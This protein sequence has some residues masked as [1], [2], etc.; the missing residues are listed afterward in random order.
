MVSRSWTPSST[1]R[2]A[3]RQLCELDYKNSGSS[4]LLFFHRMFASFRCLHFSFMHVFFSPTPDDGATLVRLDGGAFA[5]VSRERT[6]K[7]KK[8]KFELMRER[9]RERGRTV[10]PRLVS[11]K[12]KKRVKAFFS[13][14]DFSSNKK[15]NSSSSSSLQ[16]SSR[17][18]NEKKNHID[19]IP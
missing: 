5:I 8:R 19:L 11:E 10:V 6:K 13:C 7:K 15:K 3:H 1:S 14:D 9:E 12:R 17:Q 16:R 4:P 2:A 18:K